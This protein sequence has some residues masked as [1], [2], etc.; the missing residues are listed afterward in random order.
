MTCNQF[1]AALA[2]HVLK[3][4]PTPDRFLIGCRGWKPRWKFRPT[5]SLSDATVL[6]EALAPQGYVVETDSRGEHLVT[7]RIGTRAWQGRDTSKPLA[8]CRAVAAVLGIE[9]PLL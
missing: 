4:R 8:I 6:V 5:K 7:I 9:V 1:D 3:W 2:E